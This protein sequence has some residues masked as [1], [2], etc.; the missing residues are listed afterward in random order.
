M[1]TFIGALM[2]VLGHGAVHAGPAGH[3]QLAACEQSVAAYVNAGGNL[4]RHVSAG[5]RHNC[6]HRAGLSRW[7]VRAVLRFAARWVT[8]HNS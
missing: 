4:A 2:A 7:Q 3:G 6:G 1:F 8:L 5:I